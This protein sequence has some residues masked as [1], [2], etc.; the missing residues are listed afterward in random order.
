MDISLVDSLSVGVEDY[1]RMVRGKT[2]TL[3]ATSCAVGAMLATTQEDVVSLARE[4]GLNMGMAFQIHDDF[5]GIWGDEAI[6]GKT[7]NDILEKKRTLPLILA[8]NKDPGWARYWLE[9]EYIGKR[10]V[11][12]WTA[13][14][15]REGIKDQVK[16]LEAHYIR[17][18]RKNLDS[19]AIQSEWQDQFEEVLSF[20]SERKI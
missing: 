4:F 17:K 9:L 20:L 5:L 10:R 12:G 3:F 7:T 14:M 11:R 19:L 18:A 16:K 2:A 8:M 1:L 13:W 15:E 6:V